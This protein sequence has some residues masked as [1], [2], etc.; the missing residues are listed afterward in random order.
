MKSLKELEELKKKVLQDLDDVDQR[1]ID[2]EENENEVDKEYRKNLNEI[3]KQTEKLR[4]EQVEIQ[5]II[6]N[7]IDKKDIK[8][9]E[10]QQVIFRHKRELDRVNKKM[11]IKKMTHDSMVREIEELTKEIDNLDLK[12][13]LK[14]TITSHGKSSRGFKKAPWKS[15]TPLKPK[16]KK[17]SQAV[18]DDYGT[19]FLKNQSPNKDLTESV[20]PK[21]KSKRTKK[22]L[23]KNKKFSI[24][25]KLTV[26]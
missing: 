3:T 18:I 1:Q 23:S 7:T 15:C 14:R 10:R 21:L 9:R 26:A 20:L 16:M 24:K 4:S 2:L 8:N 11:L 25:R 12:S 19:N 22:T 17:F 5:G 13:T 6:Q